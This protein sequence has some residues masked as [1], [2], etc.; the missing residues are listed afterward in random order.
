[1]GKGYIQIPW[2]NVKYITVERAFN[3]WY[4]GFIV[5]TSCYVEISHSQ[6]AYTTFRVV[7]AWLL[8]ALSRRYF[9][10]LV[11]ACPAFSYS[12]IYKPHYFSQKP[13]INNWS[14]CECFESQ[15]VWALC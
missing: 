3:F 8:E 13:D 7:S 6:V 14:S 10:L 12:L 4:R 5:Y 15:E 11:S 2:R 1:L 9:Q